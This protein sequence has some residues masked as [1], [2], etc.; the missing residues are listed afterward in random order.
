ME[1][2]DRGLQQ[3]GRRRFPQTRRKRGVA[4][5]AA[6]QIQEAGCSHSPGRGDTG[7]L[8]LWRDALIRARK[9]PHREFDVAAGQFAPA[10]DRA[11]IGRLR[12]TVEEVA[13]PRPR[14]VA[15]QREGLAQ[16]AVV[17]LAPGGHPAGEIAWTQDHVATPV[18]M[19]TGQY[20]A[21][22]ERFRVSTT[23]HCA[24][25]TLLLPAVLL[26]VLVFGLAGAA[27]FGASLLRTAAHGSEEV[28]ASGIFFSDSL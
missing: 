12:I 15:R 21:G 27:A 20:R 22:G 11:H 7:K 13:R 16:I 24:Y 1:R 8:A 3:C 23:G 25:R 5:G 26:P 18:Q 17:R 28:L 4:D 6:G 14:A 2:D 10:F 9:A 19:T